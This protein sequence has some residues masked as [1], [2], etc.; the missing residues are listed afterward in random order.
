MLCRRSNT[1]RQPRIPSAN[2]F[3][4]SLNA[5]GRGVPK[6]TVTASK[7]YLA[8]A[9]GG[10]AGAQSLMEQGYYFGDSGFQKSLDRAAYWL[11]RPANQADDNAEFLLALMYANG[12]AFPTDDGATFQLRADRHC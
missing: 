6:D 1:S 2:I 7:W 10:Y 3:L 12:E 4:A 9:E 11:T 5:F 8:A